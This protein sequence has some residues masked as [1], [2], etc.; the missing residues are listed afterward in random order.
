MPGTVTYRAEA[1]RFRN[2]DL[3]YP[4]TDCSI[5]VW[6]LWLLS[7]SCQL[8]SR[9]ADRLLYDISQ[10]EAHS[11]DSTLNYKSRKTGISSIH[12]TDIRTTKCADMCWHV[13]TFADMCWHVLTHTSHKTVIKPGQLAECLKFIFRSSQNPRP[14]CI[15]FGVRSEQCK[16]DPCLSPPPTQTENDISSFNT[17]QLTVPAVFTLHCAEL[18]DQ[19]SLKIDEGFSI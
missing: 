5:C 2:T 14:Y 18:R 6:L 3:G 19:S 1:R 10:K 16:V 11:S 13:L 8:F 7:T 12:Q 9:C 4:L 17:K 15:Q